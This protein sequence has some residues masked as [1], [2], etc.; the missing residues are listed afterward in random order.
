MT[1]LRSKYLRCQLSDGDR[2]VAPNNQMQRTCRKV[3]HCAKRRAQ[4]APFQ[5]AADLGVRR[6]KMRAVLA[7]VLLVGCWPAHG[8]DGRGITLFRDMEPGVYVLRKCRSSSAV[9]ELVERSPKG[10]EKRT[11]FCEAR[12]FEPKAWGFLHVNEPRQWRYC[13]SMEGYAE[14][15]PG[16]ISEVGWRITDCCPWT[17]R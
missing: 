2:V 13:R 15:R 17:G 10:R 6:S 8:D 5:H 14:D 7:I 4:C 9:G 12:R 16:G 1:I 11:R 3:T